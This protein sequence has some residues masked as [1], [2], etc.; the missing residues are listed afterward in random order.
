M[1]VFEFYLVGDLSNDCLVDL[2]DI[3][4]FTDNWLKT[5]CAAINNW[6]D[7]A[8]VDK[9]GKVTLF[10]FADIAVNWLESTA[11]I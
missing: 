4:L 6:C 5:G 10:D 1:G 8:D 11:G 7:G 9:D 3:G 2:S